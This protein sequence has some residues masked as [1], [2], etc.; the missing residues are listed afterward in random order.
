MSRAAELVAAVERFNRF[1]HQWSD[2]PAAPEYPPADYWD[3]LELLLGAFDLPGGIP[4]DCLGLQTAVRRLSEQYTLFDQSDS[5]LPG[6]NFWSAREGLESALKRKEVAKSLPPLESMQQLHEEKVPHEQIARMYGL[7]DDM[8]KGKAH[9]VA[10]ELAKPGSVIDENW[11]DPRLKELGVQV[12]VDAPAETASDCPESSED[13]WL[14]KVPVVQAAQMLGRSPHEVSAEWRAFEKQY[15][16][17]GHEAAIRSSQEKIAEL[18]GGEAPAEQHPR[19]RKRTRSDA[20][21]I[22]D[23]DSEQP[24]MALADSAGAF[25]TLSDDDLRAQCTAQGIGFTPTTKRQA[26]I[27]KL[28]QAAAVV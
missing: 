11:V 10:K 12:G 13:L 9:L 7:V 20:A 6:D 3:E 21:E 22:H 23:G 4:H 18:D 16:K 19:K 26:L 1:H 24:E 8:G 25:E 15:A 14:Q 28:Q 5:A 17:H 2:N 27:A